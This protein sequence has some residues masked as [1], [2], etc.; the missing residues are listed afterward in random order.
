MANLLV[1]VLDDIEKFPEVIEAWEEVGVPGVTIL[2]SVGTRRL[3]ERVQRDD[4][5]L[6]PSLRSL[7]SSDEDHNRTL[8]TVV[9]D[10]AI[11]DAAISAAQKVTGNF[12]EPNTGILFVIPVSRAWG[13]PSPKRRRKRSAKSAS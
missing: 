1:L 9:E 3:Q 6:I 10:D 13:V 4:M 11:L 7:F 5:P 12:K 8:F 2:D